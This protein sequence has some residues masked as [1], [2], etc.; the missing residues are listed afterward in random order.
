MGN[1]K[2]EQDTTDVQDK[3]LLPD[4]RLIIEKIINRKK[5]IQNNRQ[6]YEKQWLINIAF[7]YGKHHFNIEKKA[8]AGLED[9]IHWELK[10]LDRKKKTNRVANYILPL[11]RSLLAR[12]LML[13]ASVNIEPTTNSQ[14]D[15]NSAK[16][17]QE[18]LED[19]WQTVNKANPILGRDIGGM[20]LVL[21]KLFSYLLTVGSGYLVPYFNPKSYAQAGWETEN[22]P[23]VVEAKIGA[24]E[25]KVLTPFDIFKDPLNR[26]LIEQEIMSTDDI[27]DKYDVEVASEDVGLSE[28]EEQ[29][30]N[31]LSAAEEKKMDNA[32]RVYQYWE[33][34]SPKHPQGRFVVCTES[35]IIY[36]G[37][38]PP[39][40]KGRIPYFGFEY[41]DFICSTYPQGMVE[42]LIN[43]QEEYNMTI[44][45]LGAYKK[46]FAGKLKVPD[47][48]QLRTRYDDDIGQIIKFKAGFGE[49]HFEVPPNPP[50]FLFDDLVRIRRDME[51]I[52]GVHDTS[53]GRNPKQ[54]KSGV[55]IQ[56]LTERDDSQL[57]PIMISIE[58]K[59][60]FLCETILDIVEA[61]YTEPRILGITGETLAAEI[62]T[63]RGENVKGNRRI[64]I[65][66][67]SALPTSKAERQNFI[68]ALAQQEFITK[69]KA[70]EM[71][72]F[73]DIEGVFHSVDETNAKSENQSMAK[74]GQPI[75]QAWDEHT[76]HT[77]IH[78]DFLKSE[79]FK[80]I[81]PQ[82]QQ[83]IIEHYK[84]HQQYI[85]QEQ[86]ALT[87]EAGQGGGGQQ[88]VPGTARPNMGQGGIQ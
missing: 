46:W 12:M 4:E 60:A 47:Q 44:S 67:G 54:A 51:D 59:L 40:Y 57:T 7:L 1:F 53:I 75:P 42:Q 61:K 43:L 15:V 45:R 2:E 25:V 78:S 17:S 26:W 38:I 49:P 34:P 3:T 20:L 77:K 39:E 22:G 71:L 36:K 80:K 56:A 23:E 87:V 76:I 28:V 63:F 11:Y 32:A 50:S 62:K 52:C 88:S 10:S 33:I 79:E 18:V 30:K 6:G 48:C 5:D 19:V 83:I 14:R 24:V 85:M 21:K 81:P 82:L 70:L 37:E 31:L 8:Y 65:T 68:L 27:K 9:R 16:V 35:K 55:A 58:E 41:L 72:E 74:G 64:K 13:K 86:Q 29:I 84:M 73:G 66:M 69:Q